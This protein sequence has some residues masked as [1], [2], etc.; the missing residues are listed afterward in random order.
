MQ[1]TYYFPNGRL[2]F[3]GVLSF[4]ST[5]P[6]LQLD[7][8][9]KRA[10][11]SWLIRTKSSV[12]RAVWISSLSLISWAPTASVGP[13]FWS[14][15]DSATPDIK[16]EHRSNSNLKSTTNFIAMVHSVRKT[17]SSVHRWFGLEAMPHTISDTSLLKPRNI[18]PV[19]LFLAS[20][21][22]MSLENFPSATSLIRQVI[23]V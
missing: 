5:G 7:L 16:S 2:N 1:N 11:P 23:D 4:E 14:R 3:L 6:H 10:T 20:T 18:Y 15:D 12:I 8:S 13:I 9:G 17:A 19:W 22:P 21:I